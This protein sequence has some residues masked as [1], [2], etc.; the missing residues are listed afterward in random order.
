MTGD[1][2]QHFQRAGEHLRQGARDALS[3]DLTLDPA[4]LENAV[5]ALRQVIQVAGILIERLD[6]HSDA[7]VRT[8]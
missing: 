8:D 7:S 1:A 2:V 5:I 4:E 3:R 6:G